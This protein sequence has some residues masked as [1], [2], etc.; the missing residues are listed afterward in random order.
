M[1]NIKNFKLLNQPS[2]E[3]RSRY[4]GPYTIIEKIS[5]Q[6]YKLSLPINM[7]VHHVFHIGLLK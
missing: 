4:I 7:K 3:F 1:L 5:S 2:K 6:A